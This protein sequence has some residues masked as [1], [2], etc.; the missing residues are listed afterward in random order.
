MEKKRAL[1]HV[2]ILDLGRVWSG[3]MVSQF[4]ADMGGEV[5]KIE[6]YR[7]LDTSRF[8]GKVVKDIKKDVEMSPYFH[9]LNRNKMSVNLNLSHP[10]GVYLF[11]KL[12]RISDVIIQN[13]SC[14][15][16][17]RLKVD[18]ESLRE[19]NSQII[20][21][22]MPPAGLSGA[23][24][25]IIGYAPV[26]TS[27]GGMESLAGY[28][29]GTITG[30]VAIGVGDPNAAIHGAVAVLAALYHLIQTGEGQFIELSQLECITHLLGEAVAEYSMNGRVLGPQGNRHPW[31]APHGIYPCLGR[32]QWVSLCVENDEQWQRFCQLAGRPELS[33]DDRFSSIFER[34]KHKEALDEIVSGFTRKYSKYE[35]TKILQCEGIAAAA[36]L[37]R[38][39]KFLDPQL[40]ARE[41]FKAVNHPLSGEE[42]LDAIPWRLSEMPPEIYRHAPLV[43]E[44][45]DYVYGE[46][47]KMATSE[48]RSLQ[49]EE[50]IY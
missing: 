12:V 50:V 28:S 13:F 4:L 29:D 45:N 41:D 38:E 35:M 10:K 32:D 2:R 6:H 36:V 20:Y 48:I 40:I 42:I 24:K 37:D 43:G 39:E 14:G 5:I 27:L 47:L 49:E 8:P 44:H 15:V 25:D 1:S 34:L 46:L 11:K 17:E 31:M 26:Y 30:M 7:R 3:S 22:A 19:V 23:Y 16:A 9:E 21:L 18:Y 33:C